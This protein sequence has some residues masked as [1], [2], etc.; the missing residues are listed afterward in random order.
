MLADLGVFVVTGSVLLTPITALWLL[1]LSQVG[2]TE[3]STGY[4]YFHS[5]RL[6]F[7]ADERPWLPQGQ[8]MTVL[9]MGV[10]LLVVALGH[11]VTEI[12][13]RMEIWAYLAAGICGLAT[14]LAAAWALRPIRS[15]AGRLLILVPLLCAIFDGSFA[16]GYSVILPD[17]YPWIYALALVVL[18]LTLRLARRPEPG[19]LGWAI[20]VGVLAGAALGLKVTLAIFIG[21]PL[22]L[23]LARARGW[24]ERIM[25]V[26][27]V[28][29][30]APVLM[31]AWI[32]AGNAG[33]AASIPRFFEML[34]GFAGANESGERTTFLAWYLGRL[35][36]PQAVWTSQWLAVAPVVLAVSALLL[37]PRSIALVCLPGCA[38]SLLFL[39]RRD[40]PT[41]FIEVFS[42][43]WTVLAL[44][45]VC[46]GAP[47][48]RNR[49]LALRLP[50]PRRLAGA[51]GPALASAIVGGGALAM[52]VLWV[53][54]G[55]Q[56]T[57]ESFRRSTA[58]QQALDDFERA[59]PGRTAILTVS[60]SQR[61]LTR[62]SAIFKGGTDIG[63][64]SV[65]GASLFV[66]SL[67]PDR[68]YFLGG[69][70]IQLPVDLDPFEKVLYTL[71]APP[72]QPTGGEPLLTQTF[73]VSLAGF[74]CP[75]RL[76]VADV[77]QVACYRVSDEPLD[78][79]PAQIAF[80]T[81]A[82]GLRARQPANWRNEPR[83]PLQ[84]GEVAFAADSHELWRMDPDGRLVRLRAEDGRSVRVSAAGRSEAGVILTRR[85]G[86]WVLDQ[87]P[88]AMNRNPSLRLQD[89]SSIRGWDVL[90]RPET[91]VERGAGPDDGRG[92]TSWLQLSGRAAD[93]RL[94]V[95]AGFDRDDLDDGG[96]ATVVAMVRATGL[97][98][99]ELRVGG[100]ASG[101]SV[102]VTTSSGDDVAAI[103][104]TGQWARL[105]VH[106]EGDQ[107]DGERVATLVELVGG[108][109]GDRLDIG[110]VE[111][112]AGRYP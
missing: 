94:G 54:T 98:R 77:V 55:M 86:R 68:A 58:V 110:S 21:P 8:V 51:H 108:R 64:S 1:G 3:E 104:A 66:A 88:R 11:P 92:V 48:C 95:R 109:P 85:D 71:L 15:L 17:Y 31:V 6:L 5:L 52:V 32:W 69:T 57:L 97:G 53:F 44:W 102:A 46:V 105:V 100:A 13:P 22:L 96:T 76:P 40:G 27:V 63:V 24:P 81:S 91:V 19:G 34:R 50:D 106:L 42:Y 38:A 60:N 83:R 87:Q 26:T 39:W 2:M 29:F 10:Q 56:V 82:A 41:S 103:P 12:T 25:A 37:R 28:A 89:D 65:W 80:A 99:I 45:A 73:G 47:A 74:D 107:Y 7:T 9:H 49:W 14:A 75:L 101:N 23:L 20:L 62:D 18:G 84:A 4:R 30:L 36:G 111:V 61:P 33:D 35:G 78:V 43:A 90:A 16:F 59:H 72:D 112:Y 70:P 93:R 67:V 79:P